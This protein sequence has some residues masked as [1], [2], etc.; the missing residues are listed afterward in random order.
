MKIAK[1]LGTE[2]L[3]A[4]LDKYGLALDHH[5]QSMIGT[6]QKKAWK[7]FITPENKHIAVAQAVDFLDKLLRYDHQERLTAR[8]AMCH[9]YFHVITKGQPNQ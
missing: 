4:Y 3:Y 6:H 8:E 2:E 5:F 7:V 9:P 1:V